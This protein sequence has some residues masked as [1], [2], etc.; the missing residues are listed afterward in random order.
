MTVEAWNDAP[1]CPDCG[2]RRRVR[3]VGRP[4]SRVFGK[5]VN[6]GGVVR[7]VGGAIARTGRKASAPKP[8]GR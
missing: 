3:S 8:K 1:L 4:L 6:I 2:V 7:R 5:G